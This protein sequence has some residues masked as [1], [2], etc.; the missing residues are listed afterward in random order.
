MQGFISA[1]VVAVVVAAEGVVLVVAGDL[2]SVPPAL[3]GKSSTPIT[4]PVS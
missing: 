2:Y 1:V 4:F 3:H